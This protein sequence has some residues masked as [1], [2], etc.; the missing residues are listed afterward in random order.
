MSKQLKYK[1]SNQLDE[2][3]VNTGERKIQQAVITLLE[4]FGVGE[5]PAI[6]TW[7][8]DYVDEDTGEIVSIN[9]KQLDY[10][11][12]PSPLKIELQMK[13]EDLCCA[14]LSNFGHGFHINFVYKI[15][16][17]RLHIWFHQPYHENGIIVQPVNKAMYAKKEIIK[18]ILEELIK[19]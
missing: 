6:R 18:Y 9:R 10:T 8:E 12:I 2:V 19:L 3:W 4:K 14:T 15:V 17:D 16:K 13:R 11:L 7:Y 5:T 1:G